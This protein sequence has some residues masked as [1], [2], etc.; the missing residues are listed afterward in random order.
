MGAGTIWVG[1]ID[2]MGELECDR[3]EDLR[4]LVLDQD[5]EGPSWMTRPG[6]GQ[7]SRKPPTS[8][9]D[10]LLILVE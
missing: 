10:F 8:L 5:E 3:D 4:E 9:L 7:F 1:T 2:R 6:L